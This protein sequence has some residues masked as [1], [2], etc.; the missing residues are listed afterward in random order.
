VYRCAH[1]YIHNRVHRYVHNK[2]TGVVYTL[3]LLYR[4]KYTI[5]EIQQKQ[6]MIPSCLVQNKSI[7]WWYIP[8][9]SPKMQYNDK[10]I[11]YKKYHF[12]SFSPHVYRHCRIILQAPL[13]LRQSENTLLRSLPFATSPAKRF[14]KS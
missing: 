3:Y 4:H 10:N 2:A 11:T 9:S 1:T 6:S 5:L 7:V 13:H 8:P 14:H 12:F